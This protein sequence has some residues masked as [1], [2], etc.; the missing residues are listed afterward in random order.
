[1][2]GSLWTLPVKAF[3]YVGAAVLGILGA[4]R[5]RAALPLLSFLV[6]LVL[7]MPFAGLNWRPL[8]GR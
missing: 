1:M 6:L 5:G 2:N 3:A 8:P 7:S 4:L